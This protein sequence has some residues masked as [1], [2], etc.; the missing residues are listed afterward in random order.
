MTIVGLM[1]TCTQIVSINASSCEIFIGGGEKGR[2]KKKNL[3]MFNPSPG[4]ERE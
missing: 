4:R 1:R 2:K 3:A